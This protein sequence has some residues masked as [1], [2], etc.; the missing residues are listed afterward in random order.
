M[1]GGFR[2]E[3][4]RE[5]VTDNEGRRVGFTCF[6]RLGD[7]RGDLARVW[8]SETARGWYFKVGE[9]TGGPGATFRDAASAALGVLAAQATGRAVA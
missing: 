2:W 3:P 8:H 5:P 6:Y 9:T 4:G 1:H 7:D